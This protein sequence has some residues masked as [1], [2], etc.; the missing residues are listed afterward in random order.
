MHIHNYYSLKWCP[1]ETAV[2]QVRIN[3]ILSAISNGLFC[4]ITYLVKIMHKMLACRARQMLQKRV[5][6]MT[7]DSLHLLPGFTEV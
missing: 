3:R 7:K 6:W 2:T 4:S 1:K 5:K